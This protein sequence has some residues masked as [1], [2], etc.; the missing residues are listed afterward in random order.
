M[1]DAV[2]SGYKA[3][4]Q[5]VVFSGTQTL[6]SLADNEWTDLSD[7]IDNSLNLFMMADL[8]LVLASAAFPVATDN[9]IEIYLIPSVDGANYPNWTSNVIT[10]A[11]ENNQ[12]FIGSVILSDAT[13][14]QRLV[15]RNIA[16]PAGKFKFG[17]RSRA[18]VSLAATGNTLSWRPW[19]Y[20]SK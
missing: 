2:L 20:S 17:V 7:E 10:D 13:E 18:G 15:L 14:A 9:A 11:Q 3:S 5:A 19:G 12:Y 16:L 1:V 4:A 8:E 6:A